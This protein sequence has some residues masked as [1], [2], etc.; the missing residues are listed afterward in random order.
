MVDMAIKYCI[1]KQ[2]D[3]IQFTF[4]ENEKALIKALRRRRFFLYKERVVGDVAAVI[5]PPDIV[6]HFLSNGNDVHISYGY[7]D[8]DINCY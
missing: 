7:F 3:V 2:V 1:A 5:I 4:A 6:S 8:Q